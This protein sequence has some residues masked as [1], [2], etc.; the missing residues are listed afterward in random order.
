MVDVVLF[1]FSAELERTNKSETLIIRM[2]SCLFCNMKMI[3]YEFCFSLDKWYN[4][5]QL[6]ILTIDIQA[7]SWLNFCSV[8]R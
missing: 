3:S 7:G 6:P 8:S 4:P 2:L 1:N 5:F